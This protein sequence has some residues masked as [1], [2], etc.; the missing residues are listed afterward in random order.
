M[1]KLIIT[2]ARSASG[3]SRSTVLSILSVTSGVFSWALREKLAATNP[4]R[5]ARELFGE[6]LLPDTPTKEIRALTDSEV[7]QAFEH[8]T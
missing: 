6:E 4:V 3:R 8:V 2:A 5:A 7:V 1:R